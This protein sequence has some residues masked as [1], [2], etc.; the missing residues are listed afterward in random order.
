M[1]WI[2][3]GITTADI[4][5]RESDSELDEMLNEEYYPT[6]EDDESTDAE[7]SDSEEDEPKPQERTGVIYRLTAE[8]TDKVYIGSTVNLKRR[9]SEHKS[10]FNKGVN[11][12]T[13]KLIMEYKNYTFT[14]IASLLYTD[15]KQLRR[16]EA[17]IILEHGDKVVNINGTKDSYSR[18][19]K[20]EYKKEYNN[21]NKEKLKEQVKEYQKEYN[22]KKYFCECCKKELLFA[23]KSKHFKT[24]KHISKSK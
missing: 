16:L 5:D 18:E 6:S 21:N 12:C 15:I 24:K 19:Y 9:I 10:A 23:T 22:K 13:A 3:L 4:Y 20:K 7:T 2:D 1:N 14:E 8:G 17:D 11:D